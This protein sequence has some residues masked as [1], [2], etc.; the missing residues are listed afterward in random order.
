MCSKTGSQLSGTSREAYPIAASLRFPESSVASLVSLVE[1]TKG[2]RAVFQKQD[3]RR[4]YAPLEL[5][6]ER[7]RFGKVRHGP[8]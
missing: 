6:T 4:K 3:E 8:P 5:S 2:S 1:A 7:N